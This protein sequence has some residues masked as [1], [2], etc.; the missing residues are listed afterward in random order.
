MT[1]DKFGRSHKCKR[2]FHL[3]YEGDYDM[4][5]KRLCNV[6]DAVLEE[7][8]VNKQF[9]INAIESKYNEILELF[10]NNVYSILYNIYKKSK[11]D[12]PI[13]NFEEWKEEYL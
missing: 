13:K 11:K 2:C 3:T 10:N 12:E 9:L 6:G 8:A 4:K 5:Y 7:D 1:I